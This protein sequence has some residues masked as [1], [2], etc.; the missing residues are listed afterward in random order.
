MVAA[1]RENWEMSGGKNLAKESGLVKEF[2]SYSGKN[3]ML[4]NM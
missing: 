3:K 4:T 1:V 2:Q